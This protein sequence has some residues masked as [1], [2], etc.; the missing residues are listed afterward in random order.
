MKVRDS[1]SDDT[2]KLF[3]F[4]LL[5]GRN[6]SLYPKGHSIGTNSI[7]QFH[8]TLEVYIRQYGDVKIEFERDRVTCQGVEV[9]AG[10]SEEGTL[11][12]TLFRDG[13][14]WLEFTE[15][16]ELEE[17]REVLS[18]INRY[19]VLTTE[20]EGDIVTAFWE[21]HFEHVLYK[22]D[23]F[24]SGQAADEDDYFAE[25]AAE[26]ID[27]LSKP[28]TM[29]HVT[30][31][32]TKDKP[33]SPGSIAT[34]TAP[35]DILTLDLASFLLTPKEQIELQEMVSREEKFST[36]EHL[37]MLLDMLL[38]HQEEKDFNIVIEVLLEEFE[39]SLARHDFDAALI[40]FDGIRKI[41]DSG[42]LR[43][44]WEKP[45]IESFYKDISS[46]SKCLKPLEDIWSNLN[47]QQIE[48]IRLIF[49]H[50]NPDAV[51]SLMHLLL[52][53]QPSLLEQITEDTIVSLINKDMSC[54]EDLVKNP[55]NRIAEKLV[56]VLSRLDGDKPLKYLIKMARHSSVSVRRGA[57]K[58]IGKAQGDQMQKI[59]EFI[60]D[61]DASIR[62]LIL[63]HMGQS[64]N[65]V[66]EDLLMQYIQSKKFSA[67]QIEHLMECFVTLGKCGSLRSLPFLS[68]TL[69]HR[70]W[71]AGFKKSP[72]REGA[73]AALV[74]LK[75]P[76]AWKIIEAAGRSF[77]PGL[78]G[79]AR[80]AGKE[81]FQ[82]NKGEQ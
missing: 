31:T 69:L 55:D 67:A 35:P 68:K 10:K 79:I 19:S 71:M 75:I 59:F 78:R 29:P 56:H 3:A 72:Y 82:R 74:A 24:H 20:P 52:L 77:Y 48:T 40:I 61:P 65:E 21:S 12:F 32:E 11:P 57:V 5:A 26:K 8:E 30:E 42:R 46:S 41:L 33:E 27:S 53:G 37:N 38:Q 49:R 76:E 18:L 64:R 1:I 2:K 13:I 66:A 60:E 62:R 51:G 6:V 81:F 54:L 80:K 22:A 70:K 45:L 43:D 44:P 15:G 34:D 16:I 47:V 28:D 23:D 58:A 7:R 4:L 39:V 73:A 36:S 14:R 50:L 17:I 25:Q 63:T 9:H